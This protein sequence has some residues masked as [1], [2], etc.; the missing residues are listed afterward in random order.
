VRSLHLTS[1][2]TGRRG[3]MLPGVA[4]MNEAVSV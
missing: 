4:L 1:A 2:L 3:Q